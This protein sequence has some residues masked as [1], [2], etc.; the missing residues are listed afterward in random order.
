MDVE[1]RMREVEREIISRRYFREE[2]IAEIAAAMG[3]SE[4][5]VRTY[6]ENA[7]NQM[8]IKALDADKL[9]GLLLV[10]LVQF[11]HR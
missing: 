5:Q 3:L 1:A 4:Y 9:Q 7:I 2:K 8:R 10:M 11:L 6:G